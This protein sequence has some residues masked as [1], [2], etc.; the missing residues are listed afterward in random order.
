MG[1]GSKYM[2]K[3]IRIAVIDNGVDEDYLP[4]SRM[5]GTS[6]VSSDSA[7]QDEAESPWFW[8]NDPHGTRMARVVTQID[9]FCRL[10]IFKVAERTN[11]VRVDRVVAVS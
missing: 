4:Y 5:T 1:S 9:P 2:S 10:H 3:G 8:A 6:F 7:P 11:D